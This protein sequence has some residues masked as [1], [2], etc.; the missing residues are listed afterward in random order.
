MP[1]RKATRGAS[2]AARAWELARSKSAPAKPEGSKRASV[3]REKPKK[4]Q[5]DLAT[6]VARSRS[7]SVRTSA[8]P[9][10]LAGLG[11]AV[12][13][14][15]VPSKAGDVFVAYGRDGVDGVRLADSEAS[16]VAWHEKRFKTV[17]IRDAK[18][19]KDVVEKFRRALDGDR[20]ARVALDTSALTDFQRKVLDKASEVPRGQV[21]TYSWLATAIGRPRS[22]LAVR[23]TLASNPLPLLIPCHRL[24]ASDDQIGEY[25]FGPAMKRK[26][27]ALEGISRK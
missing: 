10:V 13:F 11:M 3:Y 17:P 26:L 23:T 14:V 18:P 19:P 25:V 15:R 21:R 6:A 22:A 27:L 8:N 24:V 20:S 7:A 5:I 4:A 9:D 2:K 12:A 1:Q 16:F